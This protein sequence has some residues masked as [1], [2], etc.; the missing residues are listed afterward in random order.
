MNVGTP[1]PVAEN[2]AITKVVIREVSVAGGIK[3]GAM[4]IPEMYGSRRLTVA[5]SVLEWWG[6]LS[7]RWSNYG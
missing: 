4:C 6:P 1:F 7:L 5:G 3:C 2:V